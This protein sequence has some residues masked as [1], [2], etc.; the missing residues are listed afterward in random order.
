MRVQVP[1]TSISEIFSHYGTPYLLKNDT[2]GGEDIVLA[3]LIDQVNVPTHLSFELC[4]PTQ[5]GLLMKLPYRRFQILNQWM[6][7]WIVEYAPSLEVLTNPAKFTHEHSGP[8]GKNSP[9]DM[10]M[11]SGEL[12]RRIDNRFALSEVDRTLVRNGWLD[13]HCSQS[14][15]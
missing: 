1:T 14:V 15:T 12:R 7:P 13:I 4:T 11:D 9:D 10:W 8:F 5:L 2:E 6:N 3:S